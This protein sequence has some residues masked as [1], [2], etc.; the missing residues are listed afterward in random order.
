MAR[1]ISLLRALLFSLGVGG[2][3]AF[4]ASTAFAGAGAASACADPAAYGTC[5]GWKDCK[6][7]C[8]RY[9]FSGIEAHCMNGCCYCEVI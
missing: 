9:G 8:Q 5:L 2:A 4:G 3:L 1:K 7:T 6:A